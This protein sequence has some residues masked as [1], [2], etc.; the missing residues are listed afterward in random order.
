MFALDDAKAE[1]ELDEHSEAAIYDSIM[2][3]YRY[4]SLLCTPRKANVAC[5]TYKMTICGVNPI[6][7]RHGNGRSKTHIRIDDY[8]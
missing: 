4:E 7:L 1:Y 6:Q 5:S 3:A 2:R 8:P